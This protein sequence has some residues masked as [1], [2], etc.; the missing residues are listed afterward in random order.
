MFHNPS[1]AVDSKMKDGFTQGKRLKPNLAI[2]K[3]KAREN[4]T[5]LGENLELLNTRNAIYIHY[6]ILVTVAEDFRKLC[7]FGKN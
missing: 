4:L 3:K 2:L 5:T 1:S 6:L 7:C